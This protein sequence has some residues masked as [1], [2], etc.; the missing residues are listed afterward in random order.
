MEAASTRKFPRLNF[1]YSVIIALT[2][3]LF[4]ILSLSTRN[5][6]SYANIYSMLFGVS[7]QFFAIIGFTYLMI[8]GEIDLSVGSMYGFGG[9][10]LGYCLH[11]YKISFI[12]SLALTLVVAAGIGL[13]IGLVVT[14]LRVNSMMVT[15]GAMMAIQGVAWILI[16]S[17]S[18]RSF[19]RAASRF[20]KYRVLDINWTVIALIAVVIA[21]EI[22]LH[23]TS[24]FKKMFYIGQQR[25]S[26]TIYGIRADRIKICTFALAS[27]GAAFGGVLTTCR[28]GNAHVSTGDGLEFT[29]VTA[30]VLGGASLFGGR[31]TILASV[32]GLF[33]LTMMQNGMTAFSVM[34]FT[35][36][37]IQGAILI[38]AVMLDMW[39][40]R[41][42]R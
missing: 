22:M 17:Y 3:A 14:C 24:L 5:F 2:A 13:A 29:M 9:A 12:P 32:T 23:T 31:G 35:Q 40:T 38:C 42:R 19:G 36:K 1:G 30:A 7:I 39:V 20:I 33:F 41:K 11:I 26:S 37:I 25:F 15:L 8:M 34:P 16:N 4:I 21:L 10:F 6:L 18:S 28:L 27:L